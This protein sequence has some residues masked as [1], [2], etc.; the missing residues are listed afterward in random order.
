MLEKYYDAIEKKEN[1]RESLSELRKLCKEEDARK[2]CRCFFQQH[3]QL[4]VECFKQDDPKIRK[5]AALFIGDLSISEAM[6]PLMEQYEKE[7]VLFIRS[8]YL[9]A[10]AK[11]PSTEYLQQFQKQLERLMQQKVAEEDQKHWREEV[12]ELRKLI[13]DIEGISRHTFTGLPE[14]KEILLITGKEQKEATLQE[15]GRT[16]E[17]FRRN[18]R[19]KEHPLGVLVQTD[20]V[21]TLKKLRTFREMLFPFHVE[22]PLPLDA[23]KAGKILADSDLLKFLRQTHK[24]EAPFYFRIEIKSSLPLDKRSS[25]AKKLASELEQRTNSHLRNSTTDYEVE[26]RLLTNRD[27]LFVPVLK[28]YTLSMK[29]FSYRKNAISASIHPAT[30]AMLME[31]ASPYMKTDAQILDPFCGVGTMLIER[32]TRVKAREI[33]G[34]DIFGQAI[35]MAKENTALA[36]KNIHYIHRDYFD[37]KHQYLFDEIVTNMPLRGKKSKEEMNLLYHRF[38]EK[39]KEILAQKGI[40]ILYTNEVGFVMKELRLQKEYRLKQDFLIKK[41]DDFHLYVIELKR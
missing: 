39:S 17:S 30:A 10:L 32:D 3:P 20:D 22:A 34:I 37:F 41:K 38:F 23:K 4:L 14:R 18:A 33:Y 31:L 36:G 13:T 24:E 25:F 21:V 9:K 7:D 15:L 12:R 8:S 29:R 19:W 16:S 27:G 11:L 35:E 5:N 26:I 2:Q 28:L 6:Q 40:I 1:L